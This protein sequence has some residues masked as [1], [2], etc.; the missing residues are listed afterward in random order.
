M[1]SAKITTNHDEI[2]KWVEDRG[3]CPARVK[4]TGGRNDAGLLRIDFPGFSGRDTLEKVPWDEFFR[5]FEENDLAFLHQDRT[6]GGQESR[7]FK[8][9]QRESPAQP[10][11]AA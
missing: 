3:G 6:E 7:F 11:Q 5:T 9:V 8:F 4:G 10:Q 1:A 2:R